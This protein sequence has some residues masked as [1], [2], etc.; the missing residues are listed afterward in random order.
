MLAQGRLSSP[1][2]FENVIVRE[3]PNGGIV[4]VR[5]VARVELGAQDYSIVSRLSG[6]PAIVVPVY[7]LLRI[8]RGSNGRWRSEADGRDEAALPARHGLRHIS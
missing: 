8:Q 1:E 6:K 2:Q 3:A 7:Q 5:D 4:R